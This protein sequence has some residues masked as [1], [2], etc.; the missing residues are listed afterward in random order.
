M[1]KTFFWTI[2]TFI[3]FSTLS[4]L[5]FAQTYYADI[6]IYVETDGKVTIIGLTNYEPYQNIINSQKFTSKQ[7]EFWMLNLTTNETFDTY[8]FK[9]YLPQGAI[10][11]YIKTTKNIKFDEQ[12]GRTVIIGKDVN[13]ELRL[14]AQYKIEDKTQTSQQFISNQMIFFIILGFFLLI[15]LLI[16][17]IYFNTKIK[18]DNISNNNYSNNK[19]ENIK[20]EESESKPEY[21]YS[22]LPQRQQDIINILKE[23]NKITQKQLENIMQIPKSSISRNLR[24]LEIKGIILKEQ[25]GQTNY[26]SLK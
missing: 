9:L 17:V 1:K 11:N 26:I 6:D 23:E 8:L 12:D 15:L 19:I 2:F 25:I 21:D 20:Q 22:I 10:A 18:T 14:I 4:N 24:T 7:G 13:K 5:A 16:L 3:L